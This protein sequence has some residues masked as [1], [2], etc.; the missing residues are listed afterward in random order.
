MARRGRHRDGGRTTSKGTRPGE[1]SRSP[2]HHGRSDEPPLLADIRRKLASDDP[3][4]LLALASS[5]IA[6][7][8][9]RRDDPFE[10]AR[11]AGTP[12]LTLAEFTDSFIHTDRVEASA[13]LALLA[14]LADDDLLRARARRELARRD[15]RLPPWLAA[16]GEA[17][18]NSTVVMSH[19]LGDG[20][21][22]MVGIAVPG[23][24]QLTFVVY[25]DHNLGTV[26]KDAYPVADSL[27]HVVSLMADTGDDPDLTF[28]DLNLADARERI[29]AAIERGAMTYPPFETDTWPAC[30]PLVE[31]VARLLPSGG[32]GYVR[33]TWDEDATRDLAERFFASPYGADL[34]DHDHRNLLGN[35]LWFATD[36]GPGDPL[37]W[38]SVAVEILLLDWLPRKVMAETSYLALAPELLRAYVKFCHAERGIRASLTDETLE[39]VDRY[40][41]EYLELIASP[42]PQGPAA[43]LAAAGFLDDVDDEDLED[44]EDAE[45][46]LDYAT[47]ALAM[48]LDVVG[49]PEALLALDDEPLPD[50]AFSWTGIAP[51]IVERV[52]EILALCDRFCTDK[53]DVEYRSACRVF[54]ERA[55]RGDPAVFRR[56][57]SSYTAAAAVCWTIGKVNDLFTPRGMR[58]MDLTAYFA[59][60]QGGVSQ[61]ADTF[62]RAAGYERGDDPGIVNLGDPDLLVS[63]RRRQIAMLLDLLLDPDLLD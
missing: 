27:E 60:S 30:R 38:S 31:W 28:S 45:D 42:H 57:A 62:I 63:A 41:P 54:L 52:T 50:R 29:S 3:L 15:H 47:I 43:L 21:N 19:V 39:A 12:R 33:P 25:I 7:L 32:T 59:I 61:R 34:A 11:N 16:L 20:D 56:K 37:R 51:D 35:V 58:V 4:D 17:T 26:V 55:A 40:E 2:S 6:A 5:L 13:M 1:F 23:G 22:V 10:R 18:V 49:G 48:L 14:V 44:L 46:Y 8:D 9:A 24:Y 36:Y 53:L